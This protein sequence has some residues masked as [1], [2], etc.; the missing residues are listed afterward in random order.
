MTEVEMRVDVRG[1]DERSRQRT[2]SEQD[3]SPLCV[4]MIR[5]L[6]RVR[7]LRLRLVPYGDDARSDPIDPSGA[8]R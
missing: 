3:D 1:I 2:P 4:E 7:Q 6:P 5:E 8:E